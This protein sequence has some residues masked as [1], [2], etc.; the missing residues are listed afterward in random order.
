[1]TPPYF[2]L[3]S[4]HMRINIPPILCV[5]LC[6]H[7]PDPIPN[8]CSSYFLLHQYEPTCQCCSAMAAVSLTA[9][10]LLCHKMPPSLQSPTSVSLQHTMFRHDS[11]AVQCPPWLWNMC[12]VTKSHISSSGHSDLECIIVSQIPID[13][14]LVFNSGIR[15]MV[16][17]T[18]CLAF[19]FSIS[20]SYHSSAKMQWQHQV[21]SVNA[22]VDCRLVFISG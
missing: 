10:N 11:A 15:I 6:Y 2:R 16:P 4:C 7:A 12:C 14:S 13:C 20:I 19:P 3:G 5:L 8:D 18:R 9:E 17:I 22:P 21:P 1:M